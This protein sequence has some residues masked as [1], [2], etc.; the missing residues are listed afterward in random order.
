MYSSSQTSGVCICGVSWYT[1]I[2]YCAEWL[3]AVVGVCISGALCDCDVY[4]LY[5]CTPITPLWCDWMW[6]RIDDGM[7]ALLLV[8]SLCF[9]ASCFRYVTSSTW[10][11]ARRKPLECYRTSSMTVLMRYLLSFWK[12]PTRWLR[13]VCLSVSVSFLV[14]RQCSNG[15]HLCFLVSFECVAVCCVMKDLLIFNFLFLP[16]S[17]LS[18][19]VCLSLSQLTVVLQKVT[20]LVQGMILNI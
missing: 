7:P 15:F 5:Q 4:T 10:S 16:P 11:W 2:T 20:T 6:W 9:P 17:P 1:A 18:L 14:W 12:E 3:S 8:V 19:S 13:W